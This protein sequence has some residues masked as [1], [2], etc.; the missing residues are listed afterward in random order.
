MSAEEST[1][2]GGLPGPAQM[3]RFPLRRAAA[4]TPGPPVTASSA[5][6][7]CEKISLAES[8]VGLVITLMRLSMPIFS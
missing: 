1:T 8:I 7:G 4:T 2:T 6:S 5:T 3:A